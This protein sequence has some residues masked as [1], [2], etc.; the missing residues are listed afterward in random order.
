MAL[1]S[2]LTL[3]PIIIIFLLLTWKNVTTHTSAII[4]WVLCV[5]VG[6]LFFHTPL[7]MSMRASAAGIIASFPISLMAVTS[8]LQ[9]SFMES[10]GALRRIAVFLKTLAPTDKPT[11]IMTVNLGSGMMLVSAG[12]TPV[13]VLPPIMM[14]MGYSKFMSI[15]L[16]ALGFDA[17]CT[18]SM[19]GAPLVTYSDFTGVPL[20]EA[21][22]VFAQYLPLISTL[23]AF[24]MMWLVGGVKLMKEGFFPCLLAG[25]TAGCTAV[26][27]AHIPALSSGV[28]LTG[29]IAG[30][31]VMLV[32]ML[33]LKI[34]G[35]PII[36]KS[37]LTSEEQQIE[38]E[39]SLL[40]AFSPW[41]ILI[42]SLL[43][44]NFYKPLNDVLFKDLAMP[45][46]VI[47]GQVI[48]IRPIWN[49]YTWVLISTILSAVFLKPKRKT[50]QEAVASWLRRAPK[51]VLSL[52]VFFMLGLL[53]NNT[54]LENVG[55]IWKVVDPTHNMVSVLALESAELFGT[56]YPLIT[57]PLGL[58]GGFVTSSEASALAMFAKYNVMTS[59]LIKV[60]PR[61]VTAATGIGAGLAS[62]CSPGKLQNAAYVI[63][64]FG[65]ENKVMK[66]TFPI[67]LVLVVITSVMCYLLA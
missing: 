64:A 21:A 58:F 24:A 10:T 25:L 60:D 19:L 53:M 31:L 2:L 32:M 54:G 11:Q 55:G 16:P 65:E 66:A 48:K 36:D 41:I 27:I 23:I 51:P 8:I 62:V 61:I 56:L 22:K 50:V 29:I 35:K 6:F 9:I 44:V 1:L 38:Q 28:V 13:T 46:S 57:A 33:Y 4:G 42:A 20:A 5:L 37:R 49:A 12:A 26:A 67:S 30:I 34:I 17:L 7:E 47:P 18:Y 40:T 3:L 59:E 52:A 14:A 45:V 39:M 43:I 63:E 15:A